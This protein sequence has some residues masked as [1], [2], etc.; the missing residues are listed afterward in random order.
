[1]AGIPV[2]SGNPYL[3]ASGTPVCSAVQVQCVSG[4]NDFLKEVCDSSD[5]VFEFCAILMQGFARGLGW[6]PMFGRM[7]KE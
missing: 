7:P 3:T 1:M 2:V 4:E 5:V 6:K